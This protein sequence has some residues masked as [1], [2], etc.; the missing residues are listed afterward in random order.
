[1]SQ[2]ILVCSWSNSAAALPEEFNEVLTIGRGMAAELGGDLSAVVLGDLPADAATV[3]GNHGAATLDHIGG[4]LGEFSADAYV[5]ALAQYIADKAPK[6]VLFP[7][8]FQA[9]LVAPRLAGRIGAGVA[10]NGLSAK[11]CDGGLAV[12]AT[13]FGGDTRVVYE[14]D[15]DG[16]YLVSFAPNAIVAETSGDAVA[17]VNEVSIDVSSVTERVRVTGRPE[18]AA[19]RL[20][21]AQMIVAGGRGLG[22]PENFKLCE[23]LAAALGGMAGASRPIVDDGWADPSQQVGLTGKLTKP[24][25]YIAAGISGASQHMV[26]CTAAK[27]LVAI[28]KDRDAA[29]FRYARYGIVGDCLEILP[30]IT[31]LVKS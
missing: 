14:I 25:L 24:A 20:E 21:D 10:M 11:K 28:N 6:A 27:T 16:P 19:T 12:T 7:Q 15:G 18:T 17:T 22:E 23:D 5:E 8:T 30:E 1:M 31:K 26:G 4:S 9:R 2:G 3:A 13:A 29:I